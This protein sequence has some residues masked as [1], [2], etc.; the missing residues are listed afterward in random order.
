MSARTKTALAVALLAAGVSVPAS[1]GTAALPTPA[2]HGLTEVRTADG[3]VSTI[4]TPHAALTA[5][6]SPTFTPAEATPAC[7]TGHRTF[8]FYMSP[9]DRPYRYDGTM[10]ARLRTYTRQVTGF[11][12][13]Q[14]LESSGQTK[15]P[16]LKVACNADN[17]IRVGGLQSTTTSASDSFATI[18]QDLINAGFN[19]PNTKYLVF[20]DDPTV[21]KCGTGE[22]Y[23]DDTKST[24]NLNNGG[25]AMY[26]VVYGNTS[27][28]T[29]W[30][31]HSALHELFHNMGAVQDGA[32]HAS[33]WEHCNDGL[34]IM[35]YDDDGPTS[36]FTTTRCSTHKLDCGYDTY[37]DTVTEYG[38]WLSTHWNI[39][40]S[41][42]YFL[43][44]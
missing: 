21:G 44:F 42:N 33:G 25:R 9:S 6:P 15:G 13:W 39:G 5:S 34:D 35:C 7:S 30:T 38:E 1:S 4:H 43:Q 11:I 23:E 8:V 24:S 40:W 12:R 29:C 36:S 2:G 37:Y 19:D 16:L 27:T 28:T 22:V 14:G 17:S 18:K 20:Y 10:I 32:P 26:S 41:G 31:W 3:T